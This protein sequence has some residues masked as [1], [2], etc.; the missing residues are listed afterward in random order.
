ME[1]RYS[2]ESREW[3][4][5]EVPFCPRGRTKEFLLACLLACLLEVTGV[6]QQGLA[7]TTASTERT[8]TIGMMLDDGAR[9]T[10]GHS[11]VD[12]VGRA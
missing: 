7:A 3:L 9:K 4:F 8:T 2:H 10:S 11:R 12:L 5:R 6:G 1:C